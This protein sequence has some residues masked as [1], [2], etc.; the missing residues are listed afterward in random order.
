M[1]IHS[2]SNCGPLF[3]LLFTAPTVLTFPLRDTFIVKRQLPLTNMGRR[4]RPEIVF[5]P[6]P[7]DSASEVIARIFE[8]A[9]LSDEFP[10]DCEQ[11]VKELRERDPIDDPDLVDLC[12]KPFITI[13]NENS[14]DLDQAMWISKTNQLPNEASDEKGKFIR[15]SYALADGAYFCPAFSPL[16]QH[17][18]RTGTS[19]YLPGK[20]IPMLPR[21]LSEDSMSLNPHVPRRSLI[22]DMYLNDGDG[23]VACTTYTWGVI[24]SK[25]KGTYQKVSEYYASVD[26]GA[27]HALDGQS[28]TE[29]LVLLRVVGLLRRS[30]AAERNV[31]DYNRNGGSV[32]SIDNKNR[33]VLT[34]APDRLDSELYNEQISLLCNSEGAKILHKM[35]LLEDAEDDIVH[36]IFRTQSG[37]RESQVDL[38]KHIIHQTLEQHGLD[39]SEWDWNPVQYSIAN[40]LEKVRLARD[41]II[42][43]DPSRAQWEA[44]LTVIERQA[45]V[46]NVAASFTTTPENGH[47]ALKMTHYARFSSPMR[48]L[49]GC[50][51]HKE[52][53]E[54][55]D[56]A[57]SHKDLDTDADA[58][59]R[60]KVIQAARRAK[61]IQKQLSKTLFLHMLNL[62]FY[63]DLKQ[64]KLQKRP[65]YHGTLL[66]MD[67]SDQRRKSRRCYVRLRENGL[68]IK[69]F[70]EDLDYHYGCRYGP[71]GDSFG[72][73]GS[74]VSIGP[75]P[76]SYKEGRGVKSPPSF[77]AGQ[78]V[79]IQVLDY[80][81]FYSSSARSRWVFLMNA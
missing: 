49:V 56:R 61:S 81:Q 9:G 37:P 73:R 62:T 53:K 31:V 42:A 25:W 16:F 30:L 33:L 75:L 80:A 1:K 26:K 69:V 60:D 48:E 29:T 38:L 78:E 28:Y 47:Y 23:T 76:G 50:F 66:G 36:P 34:R 63:Q 20:C 71:V 22:F 14:M 77:C 12:D 70:G 44:V 17:A 10:E 19:F 58:A 79:T 54:G 46:T 67:F 18:L 39:T 65:V 52:L 24:K 15:V 40:Y 68:E 43:T 59:L 45:M 35:D 51:T 55:H 27:K 7:H 64:R 2:P 72:K 74:T 11:F 41:S 8:S 3:A 5:P 4:D 32:I 13:D 57:F 21:E 6:D